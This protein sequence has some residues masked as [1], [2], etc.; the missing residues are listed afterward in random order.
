MQGVFVA[1]LLSGCGTILSGTTQR[2]GLD[3]TPAGAE[4]NVYRWGGELVAGPATSPGTF[5]VHRPEHGQPYLITAAHTG[6]CPRYWITTNSISPGGW[7]T[8]LVF[9]GIIPLSIDTASGGLF[10]INPDPVEA[11][12]DQEASCGP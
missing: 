9:N 7:L 2:V 10:S 11:S 4:V 8:V 6:H 1:A 5:K 12:L 3:V